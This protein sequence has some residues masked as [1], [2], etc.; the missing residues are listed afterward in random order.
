MF[1]LQ[2]Y[3]NVLQVY[4]ANL[5][6]QKEVS[7]LSST[8]EKLQNDLSDQERKLNEKI[9]EQDSLINTLQKEKIKMQ[10]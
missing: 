3:F 5:E 6:H 7:T 4:T 2:L 8:I 9:Q 10:V 1:N